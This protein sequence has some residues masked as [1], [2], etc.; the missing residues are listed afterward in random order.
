MKIIIGHF[1]HEAN[2]FAENKTSYEE[3][4]G[5]GILIG[6]ESVQKSEG[7]AVYLGGIIR[8]CREE[9]IEIIPTCAYTCAAPTLTEECVNKML[10]HILPVVEK[11]KDEIDGICMA[12]H[13]AGVSEEHDD[14]E[15]YVLARLRQIVGN[16]MP[17]T[18]CLDLHGNITEEMTQLANGLFGI[19]K[20][21]HTDKEAAG[22]LAMKT[23]AR[24]M[25][26]KIQVETAVERLPM[27][28]PISTGMTANP[29]FPEMEAY[30]EAYTKQ[31]GLIYAS[32]FH[33]FPYADVPGSGASVVVVAEKGKDVKKAARQLAE[34]VWERRHYFNVHVLSPTEAMDLAEQEV[35]P[36]YIVINEMSDNPGGG[37]PGDGTHLLREMLNRNLPGSIFGYMVDPIAV[38]E[39]FQK[40]PG[41]TISFSLGGRH[42]KIF[43]EPIAIQDANII[44]Q[45]LGNYIYTSP[46]LR[47]AAGKLGKC[48]RIK[49]GNVEIIIGSVRNQTFDDRPFAVTGA[50]LREYRYVGLKSTQHFRGFFGDAACR[51]ISTDPPGLNSGDLSVFD[52]QKIPRP[53]YPLDE[54]VVF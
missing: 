41:D 15:T 49:V 25:K 22:Y 5:R 47:G 40:K 50:D 48:A 45:S 34:F 42:E 36:G 12:L 1:G 13:G 33:G 14:L 9:N 44:S 18:V 7:T 17:I 38:E 52:F 27:L 4:I 46:N 29:P 6:E 53:I 35:A 21:P 16:T 8:A 20:Y 26:E 2:T 28:V 37:C 23:L 24:M 31:E 3:F 30:F 32:F 10:E 39:I 54:N 43:G 19:R 51:I 11:H